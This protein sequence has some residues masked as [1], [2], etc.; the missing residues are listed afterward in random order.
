[1]T[2]L[3]WQKQGTQK[4]ALKKYRSECRF[5][6]FCKNNHFATI[7]GFGREMKDLAGKTLTIKNPTSLAIF[8]LESINLQNK[9]VDLFIIFRFSPLP[10]EAP[11]NEEKR[12]EEE[13]SALYGY[14]L[15]LKGC[16]APEDGEYIGTLA[17]VET[18]IIDAAKR[19]NIKMAHIAADVPLAQNLAFKNKSGLEMSVIA[20]RA[21]KKTNKLIPASEDR[22]W[23]SKDRKSKISAAKIRTMSSLDKQKQLMIGGG[24]FVILIIIGVILKQYYFSDN[25]VQQI[26]KKVAPPPPPTAYTA[27]SLINACLGQYDKLVVN[28][29]KWQTTS[30]RCTAKGIDL[31]YKSNNGSL[32]DL[33]KFTGESAIVYNQNGA[34]L[35]IDLV[36]AKLVPAIYNNSNL[37][38]EVDRL[39]DISKKMNIKANITQNKFTLV[40]PYSPVFLYQNGIIN[41]FNLT[42][43]NMSVDQ[44]AFQKWDVKGEFNVPTIKK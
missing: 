23:Q 7:F 9:N 5:E 37:T 10:K 36:T 12:R 21:D 31:S 19:Y 4:R 3:I 30:L 33:V 41:D 44:S 42:E 16:V 2:D 18:K 43:I 29:E 39:N 15:L 34:T 27:V 32:E 17:D 6:Y 1:V 38:G 14:V 13:A 22:F 35:H 28:S 8:I 11:T 24:I 20:N 25:E 40:S 26:V